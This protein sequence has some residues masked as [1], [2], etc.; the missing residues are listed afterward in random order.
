MCSFLAATEGGP[1][2]RCDW[3]V[4]PQTYR[5]SGGLDGSEDAGAGVEDRPP[6]DVRRHQDDVRVDR[7]GVD[8]NEDRG[9]RSEDAEIDG[10]TSGMVQG[11]HMLILGTDPCT[12]CCR[13]AADLR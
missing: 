5:P 1:G 13:F 7:P 10:G 2:W 3:T 8:G 4:R 9:S 11:C 12:S 6:N